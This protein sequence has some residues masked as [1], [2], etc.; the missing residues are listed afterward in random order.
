MHPQ[1]LR[2]KGLSGADK[3]AGRIATEGAVARYIHP[4]SRLGVLLEVNCETDFVA[5]G[6]AFNALTNGLAMQIA[7]S[8]GLE[9]VAADEIPA[10]VFEKELEVEMGREDL[11]SK[12]RGVC[13]CACP[14]A[15]VR[16]W[17][18]ARPQN[19]TAAASLCQRPPLPV[20]PQ[21]P[22][23]Q[24]ATRVRVPPP[25]LQP[26]AIRKK[27][28]EGRVKKIATERALLEQPYLVDPSKTVAEAVKATIAAVG[29]NV[30]GP[31][32]PR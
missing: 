12:V 31:E 7:A 29:E 27:I 25:S 21:A 30:Q 13:V 8:P 2:Q 5:A 15:C 22:L 1:W 3:K 9:Y 14:C 19:S 4:G 23:I 20:R 17:R 18:G 32:A 6:E 28:A 24:R 11:Q 26:E 16:G 10:E